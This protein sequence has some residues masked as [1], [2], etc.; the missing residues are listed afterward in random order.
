MMTSTG[1]KVMGQAREAM[2][3]LT[4][5]ATEAHDLD[6]VVASYGDDAVLV[7][8]DAGEVK[9]KKAI[10]DYWR[11]FVDGFSE[12]RY[13][14]IS[15]LEAG[16]RAVDEGYFVGTHTGTMT[17]SSGEK[18]D[19][20]GKRIKLRSCDIATVQEGKITEH[21]LYFDEGDFMRQLGL[22]ETA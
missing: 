8:P 10:A 18:L 14:T 6:S 13:E 1:V 4:A 17:L 7:T 11:P 19:A 5:A 21:H 15:K 12:A 2:D 16:N 3:R 9:G 22:V 20:T